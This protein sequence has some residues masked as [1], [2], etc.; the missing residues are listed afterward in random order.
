MTIVI[1]VSPH[2]ARKTN[3][4]LSVT[5]LLALFTCNKVRGGTLA[6]CNRFVLASEYGT[7]EPSSKSGF[8]K[9]IGWIDRRPFLGF[10]P[11]P[12]AGTKARRKNT[13]HPRTKK[14]PRRKGLECLRGF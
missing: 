10:E 8:K 1:P 4:L 11:V 9:Y 12:V 6:D 3:E 13:G 7:V 14:K 2:L 5:L